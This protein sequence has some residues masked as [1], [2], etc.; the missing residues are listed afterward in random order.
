MKNKIVEI[1]GTVFLVLLVVIVLY[2]MLLSYR[3]CTDQGGTLV[4]GPYWFECVD[5]GGE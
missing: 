5:K 3:D 1:I 2:G 4:K